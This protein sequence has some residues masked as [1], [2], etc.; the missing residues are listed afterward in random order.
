MITID[1]DSTNYG[2]KI[3]VIGVGGGGGNA[4]NSMIQRGL[5][6]VDFIAANT[7]AQALSKNSAGTKLHI[8]KEST[9]GLGA[10]GRPE[11]GKEA[12]EENADDIREY[13]SGS[14]MIFVTAGMGGGTG[15]GG[16]PVV[17]RIGRELGALVV[18][19][20]T[21][22]FNFEAKKRANIAEQGINELREYV[23]ALIVIPNEKLLSI[24]D[25]NTSFIEAFQKVD[26]VLYNATRGISDIISGNGYINVDF[27]DVRSI[28]K[29]MGDALMGIGI[30]SGEHRAIAAAQNALNSPLLEGVSITG[31]Q[32]LLVNISGGSSMTMHEIGEAV[33][34]I[35]ENA[36]NDVNLIHGIVYDESLD[37]KLM[38]TVVATGF[39]RGQYQVTNSMS[40]PQIN[41]QTT[42]PTI[43]RHI[44]TQTSIPLSAAPSSAPSMRT[45]PVHAQ[46]DARQQKVNVKPVKVYGDID[47]EQSAPQLI[48]AVQEKT[49]EPQVAI[50]RNQPAFIRR[51]DPNAVRQANGGSIRISSVN[52]LP[53]GV[54]SNSQPVIIRDPKSSVVEKPAFLRKIMD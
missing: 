15:T 7:D 41:V 36:G 44:A 28:M 37:D 5:T 45:I 50:T 3:R 21:N 14:D 25:R 40:A 24:I 43:E 54:R 1:T 32:G 20:V 34:I 4:I 12:A 17:A 53:N 10:G 11:I 47:D 42:Q 38:I 46:Q 48:Q 9:R 16:A 31:A 52:D 26:D 33:S 8:G 29:D 6:G 13:L 18:G 49:Q 30:A 22:P 19:I 51:T 27:A 35:E 2:A 39:K 23:D